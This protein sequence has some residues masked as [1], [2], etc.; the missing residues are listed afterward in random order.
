[1][2]QPE[3]MISDIL[4]KPETDDCSSEHTHFAACDSQQSSSNVQH[5]ISA[6]M[7]S[8]DDG[9]QQ[10]LQQNVFDH[11]HNRRHVFLSRHFVFCFFYSS[12]TARASVEKKL[13]A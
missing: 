12:S 13:D 2:Q 10:R 3:K 11:R 1:M 6:S 5:D 4:R 7:N 8:E 9:P